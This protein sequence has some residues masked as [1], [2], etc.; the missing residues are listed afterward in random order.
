VVPPPC[1]GALCE[2]TPLDPPSLG[3]SSLQRRRKPLCPLRRSSAITRQSDPRRGGAA[4]GTADGPLLGGAADGPPDIP[5]AK[6]CLTVQLQR[7]VQSV[8]VTHS[9]CAPQCRL[10]WLKAFDGVFALANIRGG[11]EYGRDWRD[12][13]SLQ[14]KQNVF[15]DFQACAQ[16][17]AA[18]GY[19]SAKCLTINGGSNGGLLV[20]ACA[21][22][23]PDLFGCVLAQV[24]CCLASV[25]CACAFV[26]WRREPRVH[27]TG[28][29]SAR[30][31]AMPSA[32][33]GIGL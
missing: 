9:E 16:F 21:N 3:S 13:G 10:A 6:A 24:H 12:D 25:A 17:L 26:A 29:K 19:T 15:D 33:T 31:A 20:A 8:A 23:R 28:G 18:E 11:G 14:R 32:L 30:Q 27:A 4:D 5:R 7:H 1:A 22:Q 2:H